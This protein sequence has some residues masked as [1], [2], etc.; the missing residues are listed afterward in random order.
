MITVPTRLIL[1]LIF[2]TAVW[3]AAWP[4]ESGDYIPLKISAILGIAL[5][6]ASSWVAM[7]RGPKTKS[8][9]AVFALL[10]PVVG[11]LLAIPQAIY[12]PAILW[13]LA[14][15]G[16]VF[17]SLISDVIVRRLLIWRLERICGR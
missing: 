9:A 1:G 3:F 5:A 17:I 15:L 6:L 10:L 14:G 7:R 16:A 13:S 8:H 12:R 4:F 11:S 2:L